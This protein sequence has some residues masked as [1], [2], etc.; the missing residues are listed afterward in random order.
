[1]GAIGNTRCFR[2]RSFCSATE[3]SA[4]ESCRRIAIQRNQH[5]IS[6]ARCVCSADCADDHVLAGRRLSG[7]GSA[8][9]LK[10]Y[11]SK[12][13]QNIWLI[14]PRLRSLYTRAKSS[15]PRMVRSRCL[16][17]RCSPNRQ[18]LT[19]PSFGL[20][21]RIASAEVPLGFGDDSHRLPGECTG[22][23]LLLVNLS[24]H[25]RSPETRSLTLAK[26]APCYFVHVGQDGFLRRLGSRPRAGKHPPHKRKG[27]TLL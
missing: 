18:A 24:R 2:Q 20:P 21:A 15:R 16:A 5:T 19:T 9:K 11:A 13:V 25:S 7:G 3:A 17:A 4:F 12:G 26:G 1:M 14:D 27:G 6:F 23:S 8:E 10:E 22:L